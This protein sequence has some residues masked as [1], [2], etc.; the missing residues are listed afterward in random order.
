MSEIIPPFPDAIRIFIGYFRTVR[1]TGGLKVDRVPLYIREVNDLTLA[2]MGAPRKGKTNVLRSILYQLM[3]LPFALCVGDITDTQFHDFG[4]RL[5]VKATT[6]EQID[7]LINKGFQL[8]TSRALLMK[9]NE[10]QVWTQEL[11][12]YVLIVLDE[13]NVTLGMMEKTKSEATARRILSL[14]QA[15][16]KHGIFVMVGGHNPA[17]GETADVAIMQSVGNWLSAAPGKFEQAE[18]LTGNPEATPSD[19][20][21]K[22]GR[23]YAI[24]FGVEQTAHVGAQMI[25]T[26]FCDPAI[27]RAEAPYWADVYQDLTWENLIKNRVRYH[28]LV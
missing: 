21:D 7:D 15:S 20:G 9:R 5:T 11:G 4:E 23:V 18:V 13:L 2:I 27:V 3:E 19:W 12:P 22:P 28:A 6:I 1:Y 10:R 24:G 26:E 25:D 17:K 16:P 14:L 8:I